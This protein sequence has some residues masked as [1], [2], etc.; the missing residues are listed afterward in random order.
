MKNGFWTRYWV[1]YTTADY[2]GVFIGMLIY[3]LF[4][5]PMEYEGAFR[6]PPDFIH[7][8]ST[9]STVFYIWYIKAFYL[10]LQ[11]IAFLFN[12]SKRHSEKEYF[13]Y[14]RIVILIVHA[15]LLPNL[16]G[17]QNSN[18]FYIPLA[19]VLICNIIA[20]F[21]IETRKRNLI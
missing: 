6:L 8:M 9:T 12:K 5:Y 19:S 17:I 2:I 1:Y 15:V 3:G 4:Y 13:T 7:L 21:L 11:L 10:P 16:I 18:Q 14:Y 20:F